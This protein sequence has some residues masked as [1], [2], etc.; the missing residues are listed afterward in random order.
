M[1]LARSALQLPDSQQRFVGMGT[2]VGTNATGDYGNPPC[3]TRNS[4]VLLQ[5]ATGASGGVE[6]AE[7]LSR[8]LNRGG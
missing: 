7:E 6:L 2:G 4:D 8:S 1:D 3:R 5:S